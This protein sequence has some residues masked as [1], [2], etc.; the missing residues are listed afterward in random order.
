MAFNFRSHIWHANPL[1]ERTDGI[2][3]DTEASNLG[4]QGAF[5]PG[6]TLYEHVVSQLL[7]QG[8][9]WLRHLWPVYWCPLR[10]CISG[11]HR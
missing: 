1:N 2:H 10:L 9:D 6:V 3:T 4:F 5:V 7:N 8:V 11:I